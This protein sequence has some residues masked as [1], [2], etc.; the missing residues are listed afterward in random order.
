[1]QWK[2]VASGLL[3]ALLFC[4]FSGYCWADDLPDPSSMTDQ[5]IVAEL[6][7]NLHERE[8]LLQQRENV[9]DAREQ[10]LN[11]RESALETR[12]QNWSESA[13]SINVM[14]NSISA[15]ENSLRSLNVELWV[16]R[17]T[18]VGLVGYIVWQAVRQG[19]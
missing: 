7:R 14:G 17:L 16:D 1:M 11:E 2:S 10:R 5:E 9:L 19:G 8:Q 18:I 3:L 12:E 13:S 6:L 4:S 15:I